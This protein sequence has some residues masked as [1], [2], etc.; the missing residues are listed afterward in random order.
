MDTTFTVREAP[1]IPSEQSIPEPQE[2][3]KD[4]LSHHYEEEPVELAKE[5]EVVLQAMGIDDIVHNMPAED[6]ENVLEVGRYVRN[7]I[8]KRGLEPVGSSY[9]RVLEDI[10]IDMGL[11][12]DAEPAIVL[13]RIGGVVK[14]WRDISFVKDSREKRAL[15]MKLARLQSSKEM[16]KLVFEEM[17]RGK[18]WI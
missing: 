3:H 14:A 15:F 7:I 12:K 2:P 18:V 5:G 6:Q 8:D 9:K 1:E 4:D 16:N 17:E 13:D 11:D 10:K